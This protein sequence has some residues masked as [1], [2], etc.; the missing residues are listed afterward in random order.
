MITF[1]PLIINILHIHWLCREIWGLDMMIS[2]MGMLMWETFYC[3]I[4]SLQIF[5]ISTY[6]EVLTC[7]V[8]ETAYSFVRKIYRLDEEH[9]SSVWQQQHHPHRHIQYQQL[10]LGHWQQWWATT[11]RIILLSNTKTD[12]LLS[13][14]SKQTQIPSENKQIASQIRTYFLYIVD[15]PNMILS[16]VYKSRLIH[17]DQFC[18]SQLTHCWPMRVRMDQSG[19]DRVTLNTVPRAEVVWN[20]TKGYN[21]FTSHTKW[22]NHVNM[23][24]CRN[25][26]FN[27]NMVKQCVHRHELISQQS[28][29]IN[30]KLYILWDHSYSIL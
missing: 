27:P 25:T 16:N 22:R 26:L 7:I 6:G 13:R 9:W 3:F 17:V 21:I 23:A 4:P 28:E 15:T 20:S 5:C 11:L 2:W 18:L 24:L 14:Y 12:I 8:W 10:W 30:I 29:I 19:L 1:H